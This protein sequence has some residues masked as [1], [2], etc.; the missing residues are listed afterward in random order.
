MRTNALDFNV[1]HYMN[2]LCVCGISR[3]RHV[4]FRVDGKLR[5]LPPE[6]MAQ[7]DGFL[8][9]IELELGG[10]PTENPLLKPLIDA[11]IPRN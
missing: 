5:V 11:D 10:N 7:C 3:A 6:Q 9:A 8:D 2:R 4:H 1:E